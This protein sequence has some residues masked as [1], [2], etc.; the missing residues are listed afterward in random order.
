MQQPPISPQQRAAIVSLQSHG[1]GTKSLSGPAGTGKTTVI[2]HLAD[3]GGGHYYGE[4]D[5]YMPPVVVV[6]PTNAA[7]KVLRSKGLR[8]ATI[9]S[10]FYVPESYIDARGKPRVRFLAADRIDGKL[11]PGKY[12][13]AGRIIVDEASMVSAWMIRDLQR[14]SHELI[15]VGDGHQLPPVGDKY[16]P[17][18]YFNALDHTAVLTEVHRQAAGSP[19]LALATR[20]RQGAVNPSDRTLLRPF[21]PPPGARLSELI[22]ALDAQGKT[23]R[24]ITFRNS[25]RHTMNTL[26]R[27]FKGY[28]DV[29]AQPGELLISQTNV[30]GDIVNGTFLEVVS[31]DFPPLVAH[32]DNVYG[33]ATVRVLDDDA[34]REYRLQFSVAT[35]LEGFQEYSE[36]CRALRR[37]AEHN[38]PAEPPLHINFGYAVTCHKAQGSEYDHVFLCDERSVCYAV[39]AAEAAKAEPGVDPLTPREAVQ[40]W[41]YTALTRTRG[42]VTVIPGGRA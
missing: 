17:R 24:V 37:L 3:G 32:I 30:N 41:L 35:W 28:R 23:W 6:A 16:H 31:M 38:E 29:Q 5:D 42:G 21:A 33:W 9:H 2:S 13:R 36:L 34:A 20:L 4:D 14:M 27:N 11:P 25:T 39:H 15:L 40:R 7:A 10:V 19:A 12:K 26:V 8:A 22:K 1:Y 18:G